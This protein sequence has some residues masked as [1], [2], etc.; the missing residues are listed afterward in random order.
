MAFSIKY[1]CH[2]TQ[3][4]INLWRNSIKADMETE[5]FWPWMAYIASLLFFSRLDKAHIFSSQM[6]FWIQFELCELHSF[7][8][9][10]MTTC[11]V[12]HT[13]LDVGDTVMRKAAK[14]PALMELISQWMYRQGSML[15]NPINKCRY[16][17]IEVS[18]CQ[19]KK[20]KEDPG[21]YLKRWEIKKKQSCK[22]LGYSRQW[23]QLMQRPYTFRTLSVITPL[24]MHLTCLTLVLTLCKG[25]RESRSLGCSRFRKK[26][27]VLEA[28]WIKGAWWE[29]RLEMQVWTTEWRVL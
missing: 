6:L 5:H 17:C 21:K 11:Y 24:S 25:P 15:I 23:E 10:L 27:D 26:A 22:N 13:V 28:W 19:K 20:K 1:Q 18:I 9:Y 8:G 16:W 14:T 12:P 4:K 29:M 7:T 3:A 2:I